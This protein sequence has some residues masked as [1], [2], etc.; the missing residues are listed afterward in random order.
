MYASIDLGVFV[1]YKIRC[2]K[3]KKAMFFSSLMVMSAVLGMQS[4]LIDEKSKSSESLVAVENSLAL[5]NCK[6]WT[7]R[8]WITKII[9]MQKNKEDFNASQNSNGQTILMCAT[10]NASS[11]I[12][13]QVLNAKDS[14]G[15]KL[16]DVNATDIN[17]NTALSIAA[18]LE[19]I[20]KMEL[21]LKN[22]ADIKLTKGMISGK[23]YKK[24]EDIINKPF[25]KAV[26]QKNYLETKKLLENPSVNVNATFSV[27][28]MYNKV[29]PNLSNKNMSNFSQIIKNIPGDQSDELIALIYA[30]SVGSKDIVKLLLDHPDIDINIR[31]SLG[32]SALM[33]AAQ[34]RNTEIVELLLEKPNIDVN[35]KNHDG[36]TALTI[37]AL[38]GYKEIVKML[39]RH[40]NINVN[41]QNIDGFTALMNSILSFDNVGTQGMNETQVFMLELNKLLYKDIK[42]TQQ[43]RR[44]IVELLLKRPNIEV[45]T[46]DSSGDAALSLAVKANDIGTVELL[47]KHPKI[48]INTQNNTGHTPLMIASAGGREEIVNSL[49][50]HPNIDVNVKCKNGATALMYAIA[51]ERNKIVELL[52]KH[53][54]IYVNTKVATSSVSV[55]CLAGDTPLSFAVSE[56]YKEIV[57]IL[58]KHPNIDVNAICGLVEVSALMRA[59]MR[60]DI[61]MVKL[62]LSHPNINIRGN[63]VVSNLAT[64]IMG[65]QEEIAELLLKKG[66][67]VNEKD[68][69]SMT[70]LIFATLLGHPR[71]VNLLLNQPGID[72]NARNNEGKTALEIAEELGYRRIM[73]LIRAKIGPQELQVDPFRE[74]IKHTPR[75][76]INK[77]FLR[78]VSNGDINKIYSLLDEENADKTILVDVNIRNK[79]RDTALIIASENGNLNVVR[80]LISYDA[81]PSLKG[82]NGDNALIRAAQMGYFDVVEELLYRKSNI[83]SINNSNRTALM[84]AAE[85]GHLRVVK[86][87]LK[88]GAKISIK[89]K[90]GQTA[91]DLVNAKI[92]KLNVSQHADYKDIKSLLDKQP[93]SSTQINDVAFNS[94]PQIDLFGWEVISDKRYEKDLKEWEKNDL[95]VFEKIQN[96]VTMIKIDPF[97]GLGMPE[98]LTGDLEGSYSRRINKQDRL[99]YEVD[100]EKVILK[101]CKGHYE[102]EK[103]NRTRTYSKN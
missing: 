74:K 23:A 51:R 80:T 29:M 40:P 53:P 84:E 97:R 60:N 55:V 47:L 12:M 88:K 79:N 7:P 11:K 85:N 92:K 17:G 66:A 22:K 102:R 20:E 71:M 61:D 26:W 86:L 32:W 35:T 76:K 19:D 58:L 28:D 42:S 8:D 90:F 34:E 16:S 63:S 78:A 87:L 64:A 48:N 45:N 13:Q 4:N 54:K 89:D 98:R 95:S 31:D 50:K 41:L 96:L 68:L 39:L 36:S 94:S 81:D 44:K 75:Q 14:Q 24:L 21:L 5:E 72:I 103:R 27:F 37:A 93:Q 49:L 56:G 91:L 18:K 69:T 73:K 101:S 99:I 57:K 77:E 30:A 62:L 15:N 25:L 70:P 1:V 2:L 83:N 6:T 3:M 59:M 65:G 43:D 38:N 33:R 82:A 100:G 67:D 46:K 9:S 52:L 10:Q